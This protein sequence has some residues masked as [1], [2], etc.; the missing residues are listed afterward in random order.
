MKKKM[1]KNSGPLA[2]LSFN[3]LIVMVG[4]GLVIP[5]LP[6]YVEKFNAN[7]KVLGALVA[8]FAFMQFL[9][10]PVWG[11]L[12]DKIGRK[13]LITIGLLGFAIAE[14]IFAFAL[15]LWM[16]FVSRIMAGMFGSALMPTAMA[17]VSDVT[18]PEKRG[19]G[20]GF[21]GAAMGLGIVIGPGIGGWLAE[22]DLSYPF[23]F[24]GI[25]ATIAAI[26]SILI[27]PESYPK[28]KREKEPEVKKENQFVLMKTAL[29][30]P[31]GFLLILVFIMSFGLANFQSI[32]SYYAL[33]RYDYG[34]QEVGFIILIIGIIGTI[35]QGVGVGKMTAI[36]GEERVVTISL[37][38]S[39]FGFVIMTLATN[40]TW[41]LIT[42]AVFFVGNSML[43]PSLNS[44]ISKLAG[45]R[46]GM[47]M[48]L[49][50]S[51]LSLG[52]VAGPLLA[53]TLFEWNIHIPYL[54]GAF[55]MIVG[56]ILTKIW[57]SQKA[58]KVKE[59]S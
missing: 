38:I 18:E 30:S 45:N 10:A 9:F 36:F 35:V 32:F 42:T 40:M 31:V 3:L 17:Y 47:I 4:I 12:S 11:R 43:R 28:E 14:F 27:L 13:P 48:G 50:N 6:F 16:L 8:V 34:P 19:Q 53:G 58:R 41:I 21:L 49:N 39:A 52:N 57:I 7:A 54:F 15:G 56:L 20:M 25:A 29:K 26:V 44:L 1:G 55:V 23:I 37:L 46:Q 22:F 5:I 59:V 2:L 24:A 33:E 51:F